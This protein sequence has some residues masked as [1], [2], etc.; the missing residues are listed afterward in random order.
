MNDW[1]YDSMPSTWPLWLFIF[2]CVSTVT[3]YFYR[4]IR[5]RRRDIARYGASLEDE[6]LSLED[7]WSLMIEERDRQ[8]WAEWEKGEFH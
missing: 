2:V 1:L 5:D 8:E 6:R 7:K 4:K 3:G